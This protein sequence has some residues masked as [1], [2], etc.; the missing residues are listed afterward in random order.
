MTVEKT[1]LWAGIRFAKIIVIVMCGAP[2]ARSRGRCMRADACARSGVFFIAVGATILAL[3]ASGLKKS[4]DFKARALRARAC[5][6]GNCE[7]Y[8]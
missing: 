1:T 2:R 7:R 5:G 4:N 8:A 6:P 3:G